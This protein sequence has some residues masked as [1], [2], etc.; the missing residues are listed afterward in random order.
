MPKFYRQMGLLA[1]LLLVLTFVAPAAQAGEPRGGE[2]VTIAASET[3]NDDV[4][5]F[6]NTVTIDGTVKGD[7]I[8]MAQAVV[9]N[10]TVEGSLWAAGSTVAVNGRVGGTVRVGA[11]SVRLT[12][13]TRVGRDVLAGAWSVIADQGSQVQGDVWVGSYQARLEGEVGRDYR[14]GQTALELNGVIRRNA[15]ADI[16]AG[17][18]PGFN[19]AM[20][21][22]NTPNVSEIPVIPSGLRIGER[23]QIGGK[24]TYTSPTPATIAPGAT[25]TGGVQFTTDTSAERARQDQVAAEAAAN[26]PLARLAEFVRTLITLLIVGLLMMWL[27][28][29]VTEQAAYA[30]LTQP[31]SSIIGGL[32]TLIVVPVVGLAIMMAAFV[33]AA[34]FA[35]LTLG[36]IGAAAL[37]SGLVANG[38]LLLVFFTALA[39]LS[40]AIVG[41]AVG[42][43]LLAQ[44]APRL[45]ESRLWPMVIGVSLVTL[46]LA[47][48]GLVP[49]LGTLLDLLVSI[50]GLGALAKTLWD[51]WRG[52]RQLAEP[53]PTPLTLTPA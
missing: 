11:Y 25:I 48:V 1:L 52:S 10:G 41:L 19:P 23:A 47:L 4:Y 42:Q 8:T 13:Q 7:V 34:V 45:V 31:L 17:D 18:S 40:K 46:V 9:V 24:L 39:W 53:S 26:S 15:T 44:T 37:A 16:D 35:L 5:L 3:I 28:R 51:G 14:G 12:P 30:T 32:V 6:G 2:R 22:P 27:A 33:I 38:A 21:M 50:L 43:R 20:F 49:V 36:G 29:G